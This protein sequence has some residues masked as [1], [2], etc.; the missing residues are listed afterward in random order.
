MFVYMRVYTCACV[1]VLC[2]PFLWRIFY[3][4]TLTHIFVHIR[5]LLV[6]GQLARA[7]ENIAIQSETGCARAQYG[8]L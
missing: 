6:C 4:N 5:G 1:L 3:S 2:A 7:A 8:G